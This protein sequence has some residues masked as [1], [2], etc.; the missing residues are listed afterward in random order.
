MS[1][2]RSPSLWVPA[3]VWAAVILLVSSLPGVQ[4]DYLSFGW[5]DKLAH[6]GEYAVLGVL[7]ARMVSLGGKSNRSVAG[8]SIALGIGLAAADELHQI[9]IRNRYCEWG[10]F[11][12]DGAGVVVGLSLYGI[13]RKVRK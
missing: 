4:V 11:L 2:V 7:L 8:L 9:P 1:P 6:L 10:D 3:A 5:G 13:Y 12:F